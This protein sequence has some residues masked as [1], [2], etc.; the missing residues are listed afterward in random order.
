M[1]WCYQIEC[2][3]SYRMSL[4]RLS[5]KDYSFCPE[6][7][8]SLHLS[9]SLSFILLALSEVSY[10]VLRL[11][12]QPASNH[13]SELGSGFFL[14]QTWEYCKVLRNPEPE[15]FSY[16]ASKFLTHKKCD[17][18]CRISSDRLCPI[19]NKILSCFSETQTKTTSH[20]AEACSEET[21]WPLVAPRTKAA[22]PPTSQNKTTGTWPKLELWNSFRSKGSVVPGRSG[23][24]APYHIFQ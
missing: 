22:L 4:L 19:S 20:A 11:L 24:E 8:F 14:N 16:V 13:V 7:S 10:H 6:C 1:T 21:I 15:P 2:S 18:N 5:Y 12:K 9:C 3:R 23:A 17:C